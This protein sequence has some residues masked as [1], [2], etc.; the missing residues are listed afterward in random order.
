[1]LA[2]CLWASALLPGRTHGDHPKPAAE[3]DAEVTKVP[4]A[5]RE[6]LGSTELNELES[7]VGKGGIAQVFPPVAEAG[8]TP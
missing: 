3:S 8:R 7:L 2:L 5:L 6:R 1:M 4:D